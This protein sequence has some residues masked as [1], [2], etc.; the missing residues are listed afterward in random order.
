MVFEEK[1][2]PTLDKL[3]KDKTISGNELAKVRQQMVK[4]LYAK[5][6]EE[7]K[8]LK[9]ALKTPGELTP[10]QIQLV[11]NDLP[12]ITT[13]F[14]K[15]AHPT[16]NWSITVLMGGVNLSRGG[17][18]RPGS[19]HI[20]PDGRPTFSEL[21]T[22]FNRTMEAFDLYLKQSYDV[23]KAKD[24]SGD[25]QSA[26]GGAE[27]EAGDLTLA[28]GDTLYTML[29]GDDTSTSDTLIGHAFDA[30]TQHES[31]M[32]CT[33]TSNPSRTLL[34]HSHKVMHHSK[35]ETL[36]NSAPPT[37]SCDAKFNWN[38][39]DSVNL[40][41]VLLE[42]IDHALKLHLHSNV[43]S[44]FQAP[45]S[46]EFLI[47]NGG[48]S[49][50]TACS[51]NAS[52]LAPTVNNQVPNTPDNHNPEAHC[53]VDN[54]VVDQQFNHNWGTITLPPSDLDPKIHPALNS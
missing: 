25:T 7:T 46:F 2:K 45:G 50:A 10:A 53:A 21:Y 27:E 24:T 33:D 16:L 52:R 31:L 8:E 12:A 47:P 6:D 40:S 14:M 9:A 23:E 43:K 20:G 1:I 54:H 38:F 48:T 18:P 15:N 13:N 22:G 51:I 30:S 19:L 3:R 34:H 37:P 39:G 28:D 26:V 35:V 49:S 44:T 42:E 17:K 4:D 32:L 11:I 29:E 41:P 5:E 36:V